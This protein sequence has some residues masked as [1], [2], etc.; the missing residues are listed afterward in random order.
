MDGAIKK[1]VL[2]AADLRVLLFIFGTSRRVTLVDE[3]NPH[4][5]KFVQYEC[6]TA[7]LYA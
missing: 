5:Q 3:R 2:S 7:K 6:D 1:N 4:G